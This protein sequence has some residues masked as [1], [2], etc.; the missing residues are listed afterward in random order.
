MIELRWIVRPN[1]EYTDQTKA[2]VERVLQYRLHWSLKESQLD[3]R[4]APGSEWSFW[5]DVLEEH[6]PVGSDAECKQS[7]SI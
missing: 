2:N 7:M 4:F 5:I 6:V 3:P 1:P